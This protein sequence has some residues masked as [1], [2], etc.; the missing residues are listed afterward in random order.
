[1]KIYTYDKYY[2]IVYPSN[3][4]TSLELYNKKLELL[5]VEREIL[6]EVKRVKKALNDL[7]H[8][9]YLRKN[10]ELIVERQVNNPTFDIYV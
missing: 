6:R 10:K 4:A 3:S 9:L 5:N 8:E 7:E 2:P 1:M